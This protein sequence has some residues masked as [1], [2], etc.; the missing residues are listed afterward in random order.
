MSEFKRLSDVPSFLG[1]DTLEKT[2]ASVLR[3]YGANTLCANR[4]M[5]RGTGFYGLVPDMGESLNPGPVS[6]LPRTTTSTLR[7]SARP[8]SVLL[9]AMG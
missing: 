8:A 9:L 5:R 4:G 7:L 6:C 1:V 2:E 3:L